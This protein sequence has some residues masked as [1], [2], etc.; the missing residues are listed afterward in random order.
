MERAE[1]DDGNWGGPPRPGGLRAQQS[2]SVLITGEER[3]T[4]RSLARDI[5]RLGA[6]AG[7]TELGTHR[8]RHTASKRWLD[9]GVTITAVA[10]LLGHAR[11]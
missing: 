4:T 9:S 2:G 7:I 3:L 5:A 8:L 11:L 6:A 10:Q 1:G